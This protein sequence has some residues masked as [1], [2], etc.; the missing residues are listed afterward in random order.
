M[1]NRIEVI[2]SPEEATEYM[3]LLNQL[4]ALTLAMVAKANMDELSSGQNMGTDGGW[5]YVKKGNS[6]AQKF[7]T[8]YDSEVLNIAKY[9]SNVTLAQFL[10]DAAGE[11]GNLDTWTNALFLLTGKDLMEQTNHVRSRAKEK[12]ETKR[13]YAQPSDELNDLFVKRADK[14]TE[15]RKNNETIRLLKEELAKKKDP[16]T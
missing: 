11:I 4:K 13:E 2:V 9:N 10:I 6:I 15:T 3:G 8:L 12:R 14:A 1:K 16:V 7:P 5:S